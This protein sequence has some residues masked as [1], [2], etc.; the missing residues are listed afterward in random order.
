MSFEKFSMSFEKFSMSFAQNSAHLELSIVLRLRAARR[1][2][3]TENG[4]FATA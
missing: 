1:E 3:R 4:E 2:R